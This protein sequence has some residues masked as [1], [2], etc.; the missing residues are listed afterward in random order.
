MVTPS[1]P[2]DRHG[3]QLHLPKHQGQVSNAIHHGAC[4]C[5][6]SQREKYFSINS[7]KVQRPRAFCISRKKGNRHIFVKGK[8][9]PTSFDLKSPTPD[10]MLPAWPE[11]SEVWTLDCDSLRPKFFALCQQMHFNIKPLEKNT[12]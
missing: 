1:P 7:E 4:N 8:N 6:F 9:I 3:S 10:R 12:G 5:F 11:A 2:F